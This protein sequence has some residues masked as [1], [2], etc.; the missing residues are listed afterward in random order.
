MKLAYGK[1]SL[2]R[3]AEHQHHQRKQLA[4][5]WRPR[6]GLGRLPIR[7]DVRCVFGLLPYCPSDDF[8]NKILFWQRHLWR[9]T[10]CLAEVDAWPCLSGAEGPGGAACCVVLQ[11]AV[12]DVG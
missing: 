6:W 5:W 10:F 2:L 12:S 8:Q 11:G 1:R 7:I 9:C 3:E 4:G